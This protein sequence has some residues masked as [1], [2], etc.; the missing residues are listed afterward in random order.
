MSFEEKITWVN[1]VTTAIAAAVYFVI[2]GGRLGETPVAEIVY[3]WPLIIAASAMI[4]LTILGT[5]AMAI[6]TAISSEVTGRGSVEDID[7]KDER[8]VHIGWRG[9][10]V[11]Y[12]VSS[13]LMIGVLVIT[14]LGAENFW[15]ANALFAAFVLTGLVSS[16]V[17]IVAYRRGF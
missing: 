6:G 7:R 5:I 1:A 13:L 15:I 4:V 2:I 12:Y 14:M 11:G 16:V 9:D 17:K 8:D 10:R 3:Q